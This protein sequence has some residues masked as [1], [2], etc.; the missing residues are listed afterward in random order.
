[1]F[2]PNGD[3]TK[4]MFWK[5]LFG[6]VTGFSIV[7]YDRWGK[8]MSLPTLSNHGMEQLKK[9]LYFAVDGVYSTVLYNPTATVKPTSTGVRATYTD[10]R[11][12]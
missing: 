6:Q 4:M 10:N 3:K 5:L 9:G 11:N 12:C 7:I 8:E 2:S 1:M